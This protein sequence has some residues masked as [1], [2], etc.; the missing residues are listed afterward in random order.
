MNYSD[1]L[2]E[3]LQLKLLPGESGY[4]SY[5][6]T[7]KIEVYQDKQPLKANGSIYYLL[8]REKPIN[9]LHHLESDDTH[10]LLDGGPVH[11]YE[12]FHENNK[13]CV[14]HHLVGRDILKG[15]RP[16]LMI[17]GGRWKALV[18]P[19]DVEYALLA[20]VLTPQWTPE[21]V[22]IGAGQKFIEDYKK[23]AGWATKDFLKKLIGPNFK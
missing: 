1:K 17:P 11:Y 18:L 15:E 5:I 6:A 7:S 23:K 4:I 22:K 8:N 16:V 21:R 19:V 13:H 2:I 10:I 9:Y 12:F 3:E 20:T 14:E